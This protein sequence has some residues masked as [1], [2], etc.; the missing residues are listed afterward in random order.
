ML[1]SIRKFSKTFMAKIFIAI[2]ALP[3]ILWG[4]GDIFSSGKQNII[5][6][7]NDETISSKEF[8][9]YI[10][11]IELSK[12]QVENFGKSQILENILSNYLSEKIIEIESEAKGIM[13]TDKGL[14]NIIISDKS[15]KKKDIKWIKIRTRRLQHNAVAEENE[16]IGMSPKR[17]IRSGV[18]I[19]LSSIRRPILVAK[20]SLVTMFLQAPQMTL[21]AQGKAL[22]NGSDGDVIPISNMHSKKIV[23]AEIIAHGKLAVRATA[24]IAMN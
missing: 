20:G 3:F 6:E 17:S 13:L 24:Q 19:L 8:I 2:I 23:E 4:M 11:K 21:S 1:G 16:I 15:F 22:E 14:K 12:E 9:S 10:Q 18:P 5:A 7:I